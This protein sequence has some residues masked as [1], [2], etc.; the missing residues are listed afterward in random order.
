MLGWEL[1]KSL[2]HAFMPLSFAGVLLHQPKV[3]VTGPED[4]LLEPPPQAANTN[5]KTTST[6][7]SAGQERQ[8]LGKRVTSLALVEGRKPCNIV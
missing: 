2:I 7:S 4:G 5:E 3:R 6:A 8:V 1:S